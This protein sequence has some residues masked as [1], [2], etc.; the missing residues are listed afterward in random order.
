MLMVDDA[1]ALRGGDTKQTNGIYWTVVSPV[2]V[3]ILT[4]AT[5]WYHMESFGRRG[6]CHSQRKLL[7][8][9]VG[10]E[11]QLQ[12]EKFLGDL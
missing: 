8:R 3:E 7:L 6:C 5:G 4:S 10:F 11:L 2:I 1:D 12:V 9:R